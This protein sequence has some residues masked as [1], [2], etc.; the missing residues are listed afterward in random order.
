MILIGDSPVASARQFSRSGDG[1]SENDTL[2]VNVSA[3]GGGNDTE[4]PKAVIHILETVL[5][6]DTVTFDGSLSSDNIDIVTWE[7]RF[8]Y[9]NTHQILSDPEP[10]YGFT[11]GIENFTIE[12]SVSDANGNSDTNSTSIT[13][14]YPGGTISG[15][16]RNSKGKPVEGVSIIVLFH[17][18]LNTIYDANG[19]YTIQNFP[20]LILFH[21]RYEFES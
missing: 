11:Y 18:E 20:P 6:G 12:L 1:L 21:K 4:P 13:I 19:N 14:L 17:P 9:S 3:G 10:T 2:W 5:V 7:W 16:I 15:H 8:Y